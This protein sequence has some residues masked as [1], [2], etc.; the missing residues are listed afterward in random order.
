MR[1]TTLFQNI[2][3]SFPS[4]IVTLLLE[5]TGKVEEKCGFMLLTSL[6]SSVLKTLMLE[7]RNVESQNKATFQLLFLKSSNPSEVCLRL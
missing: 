2:L 3:I 5:I 4:H 7:P 6:G 1:F